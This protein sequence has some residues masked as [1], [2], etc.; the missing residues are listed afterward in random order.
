MIE[1]I[2]LLMKEMEKYEKCYEKTQVTLPRNQRGPL[3]PVRV[4]IKKKKKVLGY[5]SF[6]F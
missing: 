4:I 2:F 3:L 5:R 1:N 6:P